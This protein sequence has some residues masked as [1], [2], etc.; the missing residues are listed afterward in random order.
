VSA[1]VYLEGGGDSKELRARCREGF[2]KLL[3]NCGF[4]GRLPRLTACGGRRAVF[5]RF[6]VDHL[7]KGATDYV[8]MIVDSEDP[9][10]SLDA[11]W[12]HLRNRDKWEKPAGV[13]DE[14]VLLM[15]TCMETWIVADRK[16]LASHYGAELQAAALPPLAGLEQRPRH[17]VQDKLARATRNC[18]NAYEKGKRS[19]AVLA[20]LSPDALQQYLPSFARARRILDEK[21]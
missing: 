14:Q 15:T 5:D 1:T 6:T 19:F 8:A 4:K 20:V 18:T 9:L 12:E 7:S 16:A 21:L 3:E 13:V 2:S 11:T 17:D 10:A